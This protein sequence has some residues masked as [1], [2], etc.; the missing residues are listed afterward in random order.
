MWCATCTNIFFPNLS[1]VWQAFF[2]TLRSQ[3]KRAYLATIEEGLPPQPLKKGLPPCSFQDFK[4]WNPR[5]LTTQTQQ[6]VPS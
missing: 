1:F 4:P 5:Y 6:P 2:S 3:T